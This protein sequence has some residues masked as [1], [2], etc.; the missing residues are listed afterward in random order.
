MSHLQHM[1]E[2]CPCCGHDDF[3]IAM[4]RIITGYATISSTLMP[5]TM[6]GYEDNTGENE[7]DVFGNNRIFCGS[8]GHYL[9]RELVERIIEDSDIDVEELSI[10]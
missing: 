1:P 10:V 7:I 8:C 2:V 5:S 4:D 3:T 6:N 9:D